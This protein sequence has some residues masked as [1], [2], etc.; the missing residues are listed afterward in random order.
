MQRARECRKHRIMMSWSHTSPCKSYLQLQRRRHACNFLQYWQC[1]AV[2]SYRS[3]QAEYQYRQ[4]LWVTDSRHLRR[5]VFVVFFL[6]HPPHRGT[7]VNGIRTF[8]VPRMW[9]GS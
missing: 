6:P 5:L 3:S 9:S 2:L 8:S 4:R 1:I 7:L